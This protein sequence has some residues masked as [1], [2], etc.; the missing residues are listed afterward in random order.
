MYFRTE[1]DPQFATR[2]YV[3]SDGPLGAIVATVQVI[4]PRP[5]PADYD[6]VRVAL[7][8]DEVPLDLAA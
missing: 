8:L 5:T 1:V 6:A 2:S 3:F 4:V 7:G